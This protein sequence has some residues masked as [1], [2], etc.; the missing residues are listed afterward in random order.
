MDAFGLLS[1]E[2]AGKARHRV[3]IELAE[4]VDYV[5]DQ[6]LEA[7]SAAQKRGRAVLELRNVELSLSVAF[8]KEGKGGLK[9]W[10]IEAGGGVAKQ[11]SHTITVSFAPHGTPT[12]AQAGEGE[13]SAEGQYED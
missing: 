6:L 2:T 13:A 8:T 12:V 7:E 3:A 10:V 1:L 11:E 5:V 9:V 4:L